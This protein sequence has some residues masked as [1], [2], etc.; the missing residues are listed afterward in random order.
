MKAPRSSL[1]AVPEG[2][3]SNVTE[4]HRAAAGR[5][6]WTDAAVDLKWAVC[7]GHLHEAVE[8]GDV[9]R[10]RLAVSQARELA[11]GAPI[12]RFALADMEDRVANLEPKALAGTC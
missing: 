1:G 6:V 9:H 8:E 2:G 5:A 10:I 4:D 11:A 7:E 12:Q 3:R